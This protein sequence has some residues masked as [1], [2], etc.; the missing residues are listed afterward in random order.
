MNPEITS[1]GEHVSGAW[2]YQPTEGFYD[3]MVAPDGSV[4]PHW[5][6]L[7]DSL[8]QMGEAAWV[9]RL[10]VDTKEKMLL[11]CQFRCPLQE[12]FILLCKTGSNH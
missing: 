9:E 12:F 6:P 2:P 3:E 8:E 5:R 4:R 1:P 7:V 11:A 10:L